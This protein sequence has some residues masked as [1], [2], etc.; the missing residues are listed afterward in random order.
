MAE[1]S[2]PGAKSL[3]G[4]WRPGL[5][6]GSVFR[7]RS[8]TR[9]GQHLLL[10]STLQGKMVTLCH[11]LP[12]PAVGGWSSPT[13]LNRHYLWR[14]GCPL[15]HDQAI[16]SGCWWD[17]DI[18]GL[19]RSGVFI[20][21]GNLAISGVL[22]RSIVLALSG[23][24]DWSRLDLDDRSVLILRIRDE[25]VRSGTGAFSRSGTLSDSYGF[26]VLAGWIGPTPAHIH[27]L[28]V[29]PAFWYARSLA[30]Q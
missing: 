30:L 14:R 8:G 12:I 13:F 5:L 10:A 21:S 9:R 28:P 7:L 24:G 17:L 15:F 22:D 20:R 25:R 11:S 29:P 3:L 27:P 16:W 1:A 19:P 23:F 4:C 26:R 2:S 6:S 18:G